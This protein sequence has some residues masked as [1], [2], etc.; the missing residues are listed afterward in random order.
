MQSLE[1]VNTYDNMEYI[2]VENNSVKDETFE[3][4]ERIRTEIPS[5]VVLLEGQRIQLSIYQQ[6]GSGWSKENI[7]YS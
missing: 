2:I 4:Y 6:Y 5:K 7:S 1:N 3:Y